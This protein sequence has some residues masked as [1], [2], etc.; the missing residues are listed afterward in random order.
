MG[1]YQMIS[2]LLRSTEEPV[3]LELGAATG[4]DAERIHPLLRNPRYFAVEPDPRN[5]A[6]FISKPI[7]G[8]VSLIAAAIGA[9]D[10]L[11]PLYLSSG[12]S[13]SALNEHTLSS[14]I[15][16]PKKHLKRFPW[17]KFD[18]TVL[19]PVITV[20]SLCRRMGIS[21]FD[22]IWADVQGAEVDVIRGGQES[23]KR[24]RF[25]YSEH[26]ED[27]MYEGQVPFSTW[28][29]LLPGHWRVLATFSDEVLLEHLDPLP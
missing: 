21:K 26:Y 13:A 5:L 18:R 19:A 27:E 4:D 8:K 24:T 17:C 7:V 12:R 20:D 16:A 25:L 23:L 9:T 10:G 11:T 6:S 15:R 22:F 29:G 2:D 14:S 28:K 3:F 1:I